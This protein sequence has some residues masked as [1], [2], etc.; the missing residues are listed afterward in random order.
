MLFININI[1]VLFPTLNICIK[2]LLQSNEF[3][4]KLRLSTLS[5]FIYLTFYYIYKIGIILNK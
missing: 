3:G 1:N 2:L 4:V 5:F